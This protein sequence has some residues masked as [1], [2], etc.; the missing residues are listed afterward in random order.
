M[1]NAYVDLA[2]FQ[3]RMLN[4]QLFGSSDAKE[5]L[6]VTEASARRV[7]SHCGRRIYSRTRTIL[8]NGNRQR[9][10]E[11]GNAYLMIP[12][13]L[14]ATT[15]K[16]DEDGDRTF[17]L[18]LAATDYFL[19]R[20]H[21]EDESEPPATCLTLDGR[22]GQRSSFPCR[23]Q[24]VQ[25][26]G[27]WGYTEAVERLVATGTLADA[28]T[29]DLVLSADGDADGVSAGQT[30]LIGTEQVYLTAGAGKAWTVDRGVNGTT[31]AAHTGTPALDRFVY[32]ERIVDATYAIAAAFWKRRE[33]SYASSAIANP[34]T[35]TMEIMR[36]ALPTDVPGLLRD[37]VRGDYLV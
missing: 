4:D 36:M 30:L 17:E 9:V 13:L 24:A 32:D 14:A 29:H 2:T 16:L 6:R 12:D 23:R 3:R 15:V 8:L 21:A 31:A 28:T 5:L 35:G 7:D 11:D 25:I 37:F 19:T 10:D 22:N 27:R 1:P 26:A 20:R 33:S 18:T 34:V